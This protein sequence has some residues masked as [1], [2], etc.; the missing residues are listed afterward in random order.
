VKQM[1]PCGQG[2]QRRA[3]A[4][5]A[6]PARA[7]NR[8]RVSGWRTGVALAGD[9]A[10]PFGVD[11]DSEHG[12]SRALVPSH[13]G[14]GGVRQAWPRAPAGQSQVTASVRASR[15]ASTAT[16]LLSTIVQLAAALDVSAE[17]MVTG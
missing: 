10:P 15:T 12:I 2:A 14:R 9:G 1:I 6:R 5:R 3:N 4:G 8:A 16:P 7:G 11:T 13:H 17:T